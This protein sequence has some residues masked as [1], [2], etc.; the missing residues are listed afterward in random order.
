MATMIKYGT[1]L[2]ESLIHDM[3]YRRHDGNTLYEVYGRVSKK[4]RD[5][6]QQICSD[7]TYLRG[8]KLHIVGASN[9]SYSCMYAYPIYDHRTEEVISMMLRKETAG[10][11]YE[12]EMPIEDYKAIIR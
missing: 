4:K 6:W 7:C 10:N 5:S 12:M 2:G 1:K 11:T 8:E 3:N 9:Y